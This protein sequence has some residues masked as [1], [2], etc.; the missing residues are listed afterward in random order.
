MCL[1]AE[2]SLF[3]LFLKFFFFILGVVFWPRYLCFTSFISKQ[4]LSCVFYVTVVQ[5][6]VSKESKEKCESLFSCSS[7]EKSKSPAKRL[8]RIIKNCRTHGA[9]CLDCCVPSALC[10]SPRES[11]RISTAQISWETLHCTVRLTEAKGSVP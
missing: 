9:T 3:C 7:C 4:L 5:K 2:E 11:P 10:S 8:R 1:W 6:G